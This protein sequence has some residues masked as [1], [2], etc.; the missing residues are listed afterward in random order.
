MAVRLTAPK[1][2]KR[3]ICSILLLKWFIQ[4][5]G[6]PLLLYGLADSCSF[7]CWSFWEKRS[8][9]LKKYHFHPSGSNLRQA[10]LRTKTIHAH[11]LK[12]IKCFTWWHKEKSLVT[13]CLMLKSVVSK[14]CPAPLRYIVS[15]GAI[16]F[17]NLCTKE[18]EHV[19]HCITIIQNSN[20][21]WLK[22]KLLCV[23]HI[24]AV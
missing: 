18:T 9:H 7:M 14:Q 21:F 5:V 16:S 13:L 4:R 3:L 22:T 2:S 24:Q 15:K 19:L 6:S 17:I 11:T 10:D 23:L 12:T 8:V 20:G 1:P